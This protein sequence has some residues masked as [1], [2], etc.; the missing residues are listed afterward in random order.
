M[1]L[2]QFPPSASSPARPPS[3][4]GA[5]LRAIA[6]LL[7]ALLP[8]LAFV[9]LVL[10]PPLNHDVAAVLSFSER[11]LAGEHLYTDLIDVNPPLISVL[12]LIPAA[13]E[14]VTPLSGPEALQVCVIV[15]GLLAWGLAL[16]VRERDDEGPA[17]RAL[18]DVLPGLFLFDAGYDFGQREHLMAVRRCP[19]CWRRPGAPPA[20]GRPGV[21]A[22]PCW[23]AS[24]SR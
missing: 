10:L 20:S 22:R 7:P 3:R 18:L 19:M 5:G 15:W 6:R 16:R 23:L 11:W 14:S 17:E 4:V 2:S 1:R 12:N 8:V 24:V 21:W 13:L 9:P